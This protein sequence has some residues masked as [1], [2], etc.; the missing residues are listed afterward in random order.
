MTRLTEHGD[1]LEYLDY[2]NWRAERQENKRR[3][4]EDADPSQ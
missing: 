3:R 4:E 1:D 2:T